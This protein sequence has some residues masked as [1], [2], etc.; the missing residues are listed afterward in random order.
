MVG[1]ST[2]C[3]GGAGWSGLFGGAS[4]AA[5]APALAPGAD[6][7]RRKAELRWPRAGDTPEDECVLVDCGVVAAGW[8]VLLPA[9]P[10]GFARDEVETW[11][12]W[13]R[14]EPPGVVCAMGTR[15]S[16]GWVPPAR[17]ASLLWPCP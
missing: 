11:V 8:A 6:E 13:F 7:K 14:P 12:C 3:I 17:E 5:L 4:E 2:T 16:V 10:G 1:G 9:E 15:E